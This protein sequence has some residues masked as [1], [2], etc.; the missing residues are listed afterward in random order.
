MRSASKSELTRFVNLA[1]PLRVKIPEIVEGEIPFCFRR[2]EISESCS[3]ISSP[4]RSCMMPGKLAVDAD[5]P[6]ANVVT[7]GYK[8]PITCSNAWENG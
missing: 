5:S 2:E 3:R 4:T 7:P 6:F 1:L 8:L